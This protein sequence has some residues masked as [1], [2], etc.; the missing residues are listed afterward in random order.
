MKK[1]LYS[2]L[3]FSLFATS[4]NTMQDIEDAIDENNTKNNEVDLFLSS[5][6]VA[7]AAYTL[8]DEDYELSSNEDVAKYKNF[9]K[10]APAKDNLPEILYHKF[11]GEDAQAMMVTYNYYE[12]VQADEANARVITDDEYLSMGQKYKNFDDEDLAEY[13]I[14]Q[15]INKSQIAQ[16]DDEKLTVQYLYYS[17]G[18]MRFVKVNADF[19]TEVMSYSSDAVLVDT[20]MYN[21]MNRGKYDNF[22]DIADAENLLA[23]YVQDNSITAPIVYE[24]KVYRNYYDHYLV[25][26]FDG[27][28]WSAVQSVMPK[29]E[30]LN[31]SLD[32]D[33]ITMSYWWA[34]PAIKITLTNA[35]YDL[36]P[37]TSGY[38]NFDLRSGKD[39]GTDVDKRVEMLGQM[40]DTNHGP[41]V[42]DQQYLVSYAY[43]DGSNGVA[44]DRII[45]TGG[46][47]KMYEKE[48]TN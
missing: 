15:L 5:R 46:T 32:S 47:W 42:E 6:E 16:A 48:T 35:D 21:A 38:K 14:G 33:D 22:N 30:E 20:N 29:S 43:Y 3:A 34:D 25:Y 24:C 27:S 28:T 39:P 31:Y 26:N 36:F 17:S 11:S 1:I 19:T 18:D 23:Q 2:I 41:I 45:K 13:M 8:S 37:A 12:S 7:P 4:C 44:T 40:L 10:Y 9:S